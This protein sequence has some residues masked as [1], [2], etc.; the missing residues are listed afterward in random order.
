MI[1]IELDVQNDVHNI[2]TSGEPEDIVAELDH[3][4][5]ISLVVDVDAY[6]D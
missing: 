5:H 2:R 6:D 1:K 3:E 4:N